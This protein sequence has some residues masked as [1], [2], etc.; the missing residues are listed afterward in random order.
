MGRYVGL[1]HNRGKGGGGGSG[2]II[3]TSA[4]DRS[5]GITTNAQNNV[6]KVTLGENKY[7]GIMYNNVGLITGYNEHIG[8]TIKGWSLAY[9]SNNLCTTITQVSQYPTFAISA[10]ANNVDEGS[11]LTFTVTTERITD[12]TTMYWDLSSAGDFATSN[13]SFTVT[14]NTASF[15]V[16]PSND[17]ATEGAET[18]T[19]SIYPT[20]A[21]TNKVSTSANITIN[22]TS[23]A[24]ALGGTIF[25]SDAWNTQS[26]YSWTVPSGVDSISAICVGGGGSGETN[27][28]GAGA[29]G[30]GLAYKNNLTVTPGQVVTVTVGAGAFSTYWGETNP[31]N[32]QDSFIQYGGTTYA[33]ANGGS[34]A[35]GSS[36]NGRYDNSNSFPN[37][38]SDGGGRGGCGIHY[39]GCRMSGG[40]AG[41]YNG[42]GQSSSGY[43]GNNPYWGSPSSSGTNGG[44]GGG[45]S[46]NGSTNYYSAGGG[47]TGIY[48][49]GSNGA[50]GNNSNGSPNSE[51]DFC[52]KGGS[53]AYNTG[54]RGYS[55]NSSNSTYASGTDLGNGYNRNTQSNSHGQGTYSTPDGGFPGGG[56]GGA[57]GGH[58]AGRG[59]NG[60]VRIIFGQVSGSNRS[61]PSTNVDRSDQY[62]GG[63]AESTEGTQ[64]M[65]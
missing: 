39:G 57:N 1:S 2:T 22:D 50:A 51:T 36:G 55:V 8:D 44:G 14:N 7:E 41:G 30:G 38:N 5:S 13:G 34:G 16:T 29:G 31:P 9:D 48:G 40:G 15:T 59:G 12:G 58:P 42:G 53:T 32:G 60:V 19:A 17:V 63:E 27:H 54:L 64:K 4:Y 56:A 3:T 65:Y 61:F 24:P 10:S 45:T 18:F 23:L 6:T 28:D 37:T 35:E 46:A 52:G 62:S 21:R 49:E 11:T 26:T 25:H 33:R 43:A 47:G 20:S